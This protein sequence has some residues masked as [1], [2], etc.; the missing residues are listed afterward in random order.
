MKFGLSLSIF[1]LPHVGHAATIFALAGPNNG[2]PSNSIGYAGN[3]S[4]ST[5][6][7]VSEATVKFGSAFARAYSNCPSGS[8]YCGANAI[9]SFSDAITI[10]DADGILQANVQLLAFVSFADGFAA[11]QFTFG[12]L[13]RY[14]QG[15]FLQHFTAGNGL[16]F[17]GSVSVF[18]SDFAPWDPIVG[19]EDDRA[20]LTVDFSVLNSNGQPLSGFRYSS[21]SGTDYKLAGGV[22]VA[23][24]PTT[25]MFV[26]VGFL[27]MVLFGARQRRHILKV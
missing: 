20:H 1:L 7:G 8:T 16:A 25:M 4:Y 3:I 26:P 13:S 18:A 2:Q 11:S 24:E 5:A 23:P 27:L 12:S 6:G 22:F 10:L 14:S 9:A 19:S 17:S 15:S 21:D